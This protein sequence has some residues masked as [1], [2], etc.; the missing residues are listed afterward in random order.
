MFT[1]GVQGRGMASILEHLEYFSGWHRAK[2]AVAV[3]LRY[4]AHLQRSVREK[5]QPGNASE[6]PKKQTEP[7]SQAI[8]VEELRHS[9]LVILKLLQNETFEPE[10]KILRSCAVTKSNLNRVQTKRRN[11][12]MKG[13][14]SLYRL[15]P[16]L[17]SDDMLRVGGRLQRAHVPYDLKHPIILPRKS[18]ITELIVRHHHHRV[19]HQGR[20]ITL[21][22]LRSSGYW[23]IG[24]GSVVGTY[25]S[26]CVVC[27]KLRG[28]VS[29]Q[30]MAD[31]PEDRLEEAP[32]F[33]YCGVDYFG[34]WYIK[35][36]RKQMK[37]YGV[38]F[39]CLVSRA[40]H[41][42]TAN[43]LTT[44]TFINALRRF[45]SHRG[46]TRQ[47]RSD[48][49]SNFVGAKSELEGA[50]S[51]LDQARIHNFLL[52]SNC[53]WFEFKMNPPSASHM[54]GVWERQIR[55][56]RNVLA[57]LLQSAGEQSD[58][59]SLRTLMCE[60]EAIVNS[61]PLSVDDLSLP[62]LE[63]LTPNHLLTSKSNVLLPPPGDFKRAD[64]YSR[65]RW[66]R[67]QHLSNEFWNRWRREFL[68][69][70]QQRQK[71]TGT[72]RNVQVNDIVLLKVNDLPRNQWP[73][74]RVVETFPSSDGLVRKVKLF[75]SDRIHEAT[76]QRTK[77]AQTSECP[78]H[79]LV[80][81][82]PSE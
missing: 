47:I 32:P 67:V 71:W 48:R 78:I 74:A 29:E 17:D 66:R 27:R 6:Q 21:N 1:T 24:G 15:D 20:G 9:E 60:A 68:Q 40:I 30:K 49:G 53:D 57:S 82:I 52:E 55:S 11:H 36:G 12:S 61:R 23:V 46:P 62:S 28:A 10:I 4:R 13:T 33:T 81:L 69:T 63:R 77:P 50:L 44:D 43:A 34:P 19:E 76:G 31:L 16:F 5:V 35:E 59:E 26:N 75:V 79:K 51:E 56:A 42:E 65:K 14:S 45:L 54:G 22:Y 64:L 7:S 8:S 58:D 72:R 18:H 41:L 37:R 38:L 2:K 80:L 39:T 25:I 73:L 70:L 3:C